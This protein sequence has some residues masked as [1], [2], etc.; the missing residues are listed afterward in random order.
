M[1]FLVK[2]ALLIA[3]VATCLNQHS[4]VDG[5]CQKPSPYPLTSDAV[6]SRR[7]VLA[8]LLTVGAVATVGVNRP[9]VAFAAADCF[10]DCM[11]NC[12]KIAPKDP[13]YCVMNC[14]EYCAQ[15][16][17]ED[18]LSG[19]ISAANGEVGILGGTFGQGT[20]PKGED[21]PPSVTLPGLDFSSEKGRKL[22][23]YQ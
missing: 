1:S 16:D 11:K 18:G 4:S 15:D 10:A 13:D 23:G 20:V 19:S 22:L 7:S 5:L 6:P 21:R 12:K 8:H 14:N 2:S 3:T 17:R 9:E